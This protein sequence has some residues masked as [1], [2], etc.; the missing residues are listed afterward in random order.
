VI[1]PAS[2]VHVKGH[3]FFECREFQRKYAEKFT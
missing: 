3:P 2:T 1:T